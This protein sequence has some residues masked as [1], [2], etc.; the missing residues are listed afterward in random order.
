MYKMPYYTE[1]DREAILDFMKQH[2]FAF[3]TGLGDEF[4]VATQLPL[5]IV[6]KGEQ[7]FLSG[8]IMRKTDHHLAFEKNN[9]VLVVFHSPH[10]Y[11]NANWYAEPAGGSTVNYLSVHAKGIIHLLDEAGTRKAVEE[12][13]NRHIGKGTP[14]SFENISEEY[15]AAMVKAIVGFKIEVVALQNVFK[16][17]Q[18]RTAD[19]QQSIIRHLEER[20]KPG[21]IFIAAKMKERQS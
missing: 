9:H 17:S 7:L 6:E 19:D 8:H 14:A 12:V 1:H 21:D 16:L 13:T 18:N 20:A 15:I 4:P 2:N 10:A 5:E 11:I 3:V